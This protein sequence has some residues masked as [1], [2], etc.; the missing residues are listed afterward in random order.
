MQR[1]EMDLLQ[2]RSLLGLSYDAK[3]LRGVGYEEK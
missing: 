3:E 1:Q 2:L